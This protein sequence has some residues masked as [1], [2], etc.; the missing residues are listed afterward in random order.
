MFSV[1]TIASS[2]TKPTAI[3]RPIREIVSRLWP[4]PSMKGKVPI[5]HRGMEIPGMRVADTVRRNKKMTKATRPMVIPRV[6]CTSRIEA[7][8][9]W[10]W[11]PTTSSRTPGGRARTISGSCFFIWSTV[12]VRLA[13]SCLWMSTMIA[14]CLL[15][16]AAMLVSCAASTARPTSRMRTG[17][18]PRH[19]MICSLKCAA[20]RSWSFARTTSWRRVPSSVPLGR[21][22][23]ARAN[24]ERTD[25]RSRPRAARAAGFSRTRTA[26]IWSP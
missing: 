4:I 9:V 21:S 25:S 14:G 7:R 5:R 13:P 8:V 10:V 20:L 19:A 2:T 6:T 23:V 3:V 1:T 18:P 24:A 17:A 11:S 15:D 12:E 22:T 26:G 16:H